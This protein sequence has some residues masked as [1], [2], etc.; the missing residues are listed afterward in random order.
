MITQQKVK[1]IFD[2]KDGCLYWK[3]RH[4]SLG[5]VGKK[6]GSLM[7]N[8]YYITK[9]NGKSYLIHRLIYLWHYG[10]LPKELDHIDKNSLNNR[11]ENLRQ[12]TRK[13]NA[14]NRGLP[15][16]NTSGYKNVVWNNKSRKW[17]VRLRIDGKEKDFGYYHDIELA[18]LV[19]EEARNKYHK[20]FVRHL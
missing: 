11:I 19:A 4:G 9:I 17:L 2:Y 20:E 1:E 14:C 16:N 8:G 5:I 15:K 18:G 13:E 10:F 6:A 3:I 12:A 7:Q